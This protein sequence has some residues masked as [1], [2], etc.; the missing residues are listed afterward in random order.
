MVP[1]KMDGRVVEDLGDMTYK[2]T[3]LRV[4]RLMYVTHKERWLDLSLR[5][6]AGDCLRRVEERFAGV[7]RSGPKAS[8]F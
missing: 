7:D 1:A 6:L 2:G 8:K 5:N 3:V 4:V